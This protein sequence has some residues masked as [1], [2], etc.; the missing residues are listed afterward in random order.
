MVAAHA[1]DVMGARACGFRGV[2]VNR[3]ELPY[4]ETPFQPDATVQD[5]HQL[6]ELL[7]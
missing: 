6:A 4:E 2:Y 5:F 1:F 3:Y 7:A